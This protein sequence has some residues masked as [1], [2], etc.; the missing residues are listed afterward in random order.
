L[1]I[2]PILALIA[3]T[4]GVAAA[5]NPDLNRQNV[6]AFFDTAFSVQQKDHEIVGAVVSVVHDGE[7]L[8]K[9]GYGFADLEI[10]TPADP[11]ESLFRIASITKTFVWTAI[12]QLVEQGRLS[13]DDPVDQYLDFSI[14]DV[15]GEPIRIRHLLTHTPGFEE[16]ATDSRARTVEEVGP[17][18]DYLIEAMP[19][20]VRPPGE[21]ASYSNYATALAGYIIERITGQTWADY[22]DK[23]ILGPLGMDSTNT[24]LVMKEGLKARHATSY[25][26]RGG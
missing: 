5:E 18:K 22:I 10:R 25:K 24:Q 17:L 1:R 15:Y 16:K 6:A 12:M 7:V 14:P 20:R 2:F 9:A 11:D 8:F 3:L 23:H 26:Y 19:A 21:Q 4:T 13:L